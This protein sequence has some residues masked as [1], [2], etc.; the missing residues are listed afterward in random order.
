ME[1]AEN[2]LTRTVEEI[3]V[4][5]VLGKLAICSC[6]AVDAIWDREVPVTGRQASTGG[7]VLLA[8][9]GYGLQAG[10]PAGVQRFGKWTERPIRHVSGANG[11]DSYRIASLGLLPDQPATGKRHIV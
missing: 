10:L 4:D 2:G 9:V 1:W 5:C 3:T 7:D 11:P 8:A 6:T